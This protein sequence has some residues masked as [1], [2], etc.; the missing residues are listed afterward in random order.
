MF[1]CLLLCRDLAGRNKTVDIEMLS[2]THTLGFDK[3]TASLSERGSVQGVL[4]SLEL[5][6]FQI[7]WKLSFYSAQDS[8]VEAECL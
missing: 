1:L 2:F 8:S 7:E 3:N 6:G 4:S 5:N